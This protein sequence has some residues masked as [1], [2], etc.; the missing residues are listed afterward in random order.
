MDISDLNPLFTAASVEDDYRT[1]DMNNKQVFDSPSGRILYDDGRILTRGTH[2]YVPL[3]GMGPRK[4]RV[5][6]AMAFIPGDKAGRIR[7]QIY[8]TGAF[9]DYV[10]RPLR[11]SLHF[12]NLTPRQAYTLQQNLKRNPELTKLLDGDA[13][14][15][16]EHNVFRVDS[17][18]AKGILDKFFDS[19]GFDLKPGQTINIFDDPEQ[20]AATLARRK[21]NYDKLKGLLK[22]RKFR[23]LMLLTAGAGA[24]GTAGSL[25]D[26]KDRMLSA[27]LS[28]AAGAAALPTGLAAFGGK[29]LNRLI[30]RKPLVGLAAGALGGLGGFFGNKTIQDALDK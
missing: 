26:N 24:A 16:A 19:S 5:Q 18:K 17:A 8:N 27:G 20:R 9:T 1:R 28:T 13:L 6:A 29:K 2:K 11:Q 21:E 15:T 10:N 25:L 30:T 14:Y 3:A 4:R 12:D 22:I 7:A 23:N